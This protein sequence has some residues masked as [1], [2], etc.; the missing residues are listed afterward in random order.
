LLQETSHGRRKT[1]IPALHQVGINC[2]PKWPNDGS[3]FADLELHAAAARLN[4]M[5]KAFVS[6]VKKSTSSC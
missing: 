5:V 1:G 3:W 4:L 2:V 6:F